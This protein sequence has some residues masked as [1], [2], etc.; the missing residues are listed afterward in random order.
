[1]KKSLIALAALAATSAF[2]QSSVTISG[3]ANGS[4]DMFSIGNANATRGA[5][6]KSENRVSDNGTRIIFGMNEDLGGGLR[7]VAQL[8]LRPVL[9]AGGRLHAVCGTPAVAAQTAIAN[10]STNTTTAVAA[11]TAASAAV[12]S[13]AV[14]P[15]NGG[16]SHIGLSSATLGTIRLGRQ[17]LHYVENGNF[18]PAANSTIQSHAG[19]LVTAAIGSS[20]GRATRTSNLVWYTSP[21]IQGFT[22][23]VGISTMGS[24]TSGNPEVENDLASG[25]RKGGTEYFRLGYTNGPLTAVYSQISEKSDYIGTPAIGLTGNN[26]IYA[27]NAATPDRKG[28]MITAKYD[29][30]VA[31]VGLALANNESRAYA[32]GVAGDVSKRS[33]TQVGVAVPMGAN[34][35]ALTYTKV[36]SVKVNGTESA[37]TGATA[38]ALAYSHDLSKRT[39]LFVGMNRIKNQASGT[40]SMF[41]N[42]D[43]AVGSL[44]STALGGE[45]HKATSIGLRHA[46]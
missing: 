36:G 43:N 26:A 21:T 17:D 9:D 28:N 45:T 11:Q 6:N 38:I 8:D 15:L 22:G 4:Y 40:H 14:N 19:L 33:N 12:C 35:F 39:Q 24:A 27:A 23:T 7:A 29:F 32:A 34:T 13:P 30:G 3:F 5:A 20:V 10:T 41:Y 2:A 18:A 16:N 37:N 42:A 1:M 46:F 44:G 25:Q 31:R